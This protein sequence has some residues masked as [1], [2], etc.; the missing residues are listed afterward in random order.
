MYIVCVYKACRVKVL[1][2]CWK[3]VYNKYNFV[4]VQIP[5]FIPY[6]CAA[7]VL[8]VAKKCHHAWLHS[9]HACCMKHAWPWLHDPCGIVQLTSCADVFVCTT[10]YRTI[11]CWTMRRS[12][13][14]F[15]HDSARPRAGSCL[16]HM[17]TH[18]HP[19]AHNRHWECLRDES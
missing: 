17:V 3:I 8:T 16:M 11:A 12:I 2:N 7:A 9:I 10:P 14:P 6:P 4:R 15:R 19:H 5:T 1:Q 18:A 13:R